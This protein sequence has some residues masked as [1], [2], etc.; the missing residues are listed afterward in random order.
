MVE[1]L[2][3][4]RPTLTDVAESPSPVQVENLGAARPTLTDI[5]ES[6]S[7]P[8]LADSP[9][10][11]PTNPSLSSDVATR[12]SPVIST[13][14]PGKYSPDSAKAVNRPTRKS[15]FNGMELFQAL[16]V[17]RDGS[18]TWEELDQG[19]H[20]PEI[21]KIIEEHGISVEHLA[22][23]LDPNRTGVI[24]LMMFIKG[25]ER[26]DMEV[27]TAAEKQ[28]RLGSEKKAP[29]LIAD[30][31]ETFGFDEEDAELEDAFTEK[32]AA[33]EA[34]RQSFIQG[35]ANIEKIPSNQLTRHA[36]TIVE[37]PEA[38]ALDQEC[39]YLGDCSCPDCR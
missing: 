14:A 26:L 23:K 16:D 25:M 27:E 4:T 20:R 5:A 32:D 17:E 7:P 33:F 8:P 9:S 3:S 34:P 10:P 13:R 21:T 19:V 37:E 6:P 11:P 24:T 18:L 22:E 29:L 15:H 35:M 12:T 30:E 2:V 28:K 39:T 31:E 38:P 1:N 36:D